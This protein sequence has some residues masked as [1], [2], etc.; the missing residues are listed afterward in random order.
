MNRLIGFCWIRG[1]KNFQNLRPLLL[2]MLIYCATQQAVQAREYDTFIWSVGF[3]DESIKWSSAGDL[4]SAN[5]NIGQSFEIPS[6]ELVNIGFV[7]KDTNSSGVVGLLEIDYATVTDGPARESRYSGDNRSN[8][9]YRQTSEAKGGRFLRGSLGF[10]TDFKLLSDDFIITPLVGYVV[11]SQR[12]QLENGKQTISS[13]PST[14]T[15]GAINQLNS[16]YET[17][18]N[19]F[20][21]G[22]D[23]IAG[24]KNQLSVSGNIRYY[25]LDY[26]AEAYWDKQTDFEPS[27]SFT[28][29][30]EGDGT[31]VKV[32]LSYTYGLRSTVVAGINYFSW[33]AEDGTAT[34]NN[35]SGTPTTRKFN[36]VEWESSSIYFGVKKYF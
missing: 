16:R 36:T 27:P 29:I 15:L 35:I 11:N 30:A 3:V 12:Y 33:K 19:G 31:A 8:E 14:A 5:P 18:W 28:H 25:Q 20:W 10:G 22:V 24:A 6:I 17:D 34:L 13:A 2:V 1:H 26:E 9:Y 4:A 21:L 7:I 32:E 23:F